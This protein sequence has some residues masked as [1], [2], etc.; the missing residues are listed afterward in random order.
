MNIGLFPGSFNPIH[1]GHML[2]AQ[3]MLNFEALDQVW[4]I[5][6][7]QNPLKNRTSLASATDRLT[8]TKLAIGN[9][10]NLVASDI[11]FHLSQPSYTIDTLDFIKQENPAN[12]YSLIIGYDNFIHL[13]KWKSHDRL[14]LEN[15]IYVY[16]RIDP[17]SK[18]YLVNP[19]LEAPTYL[20][21]NPTFIFSK[22]PVLEISS[23]RI[24]EI[25]LQHKSIQFMVSDSVI[26]YIQDHKI[27]G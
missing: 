4:F 11:E 1:I 25:L 12:S 22:A 8:M 19:P 6:S 27:Y 10:P 14:I 5:V 21:P 24:R 15:R 20:S 26:R 2:I 3:H 7:P 18:E 17:A 16:P 23:T 9:A 13:D